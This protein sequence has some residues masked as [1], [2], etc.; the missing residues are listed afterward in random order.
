MAT[1]NRKDLEFI[2]QQIQVA[3]AHA[4]GADLTTLVPTVFAPVGLRTVDG[5][6]NNLLPGQSTFGAA[7]QPF[8]TLIDPQFSPPYNAPGLVFDAQ[9]RVIS[10][11]VADMSINNPAA[12]QAFVQAGLGSIR[13][14]DGALLDADGNVI[15]PNAVLTIP[16]VTP[17]VGLS[18]PYN[19]WFTFFGQFFDHGLDLVNKNPAEAVIIPLQPDDPLF[20][21]AP[22]APNFMVLSRTLHDANGNAVNQTTPF[23][24]QNQTYTSHASH[25]VFLREYVLDASGHPVATGKLLNHADG[26]LPTWADVKTQ[27]HNLLH[28]DL[29]NMDVLNLPLLVTDP[30]GKFVPGPNGFP[31]LVINAGPPPVTVS[32]TAG[33][34]VDASAGVRTGHPFLADIA[35]A[36]APVSDT[37]GI[38]TA[39][40]DTEINTGPQAPG[41]YDDELLDR[42]YIT[43]DG[44]GNENIALTSVHHV[45]HSEHNRQIEAIKTLVTGTGDPDFIASWHLADGSWNG[46]RLF[47]A[48]RFATEMQY[49]HLVF[50]EF[51]RRVQP[52]INEF[53]VPDGYNV[54][55]D[56]AIVAEFAHAVF[57][58]GHT[59]L[60]E[61]VDRFDPNFAADDKTLIEA[62]LNPVGFNNNGD[63]SPEEAAG[64]IVRGMTRQVGNE[65]DEF[66]T[67]AVRNN[68]LGLPLD[69]AALN[70]ARGR[71]TGLPSLNEARRE[72]FTQTSESKLAPY[73]SWVDLTQH[74][75]HEASAI[76]FIAAYGTHAALTAADV[77]TVEEKRAVAVALVMGGSATINAG[78]P[79]ERIFTADDTDRL[80]F[81]NSTGA[82]ANTPAG[83]TT[84]GVDDIDLWIGGLAERQTPFGGLL[85]STFNFVF[86]Q[87]LENL[88]NGD[89]FYYLSRTAGMHFGTELENNS[90]A[91]LVMLNTDAT[92]LPADIFSTPSWIFEVDQLKQYTGLGAGGHDDPTGGTAQVPLVIRDD[93]ATA[94]PDT[95]YLRYTGQDHVVLGGT[96][97]NDTLISS[98]GDDTFYGDEGNDRIEG[99]DG[100]DMIHGGAGDDIITDSGGDDVI[101]GEA[102]NDVIHGGNGL[103]LILGQ[104]GNDFIITGEDISTTFA[105]AGNDFIL[106]SK[107]NLPTLGNEGDDWIELGTQDGAGGDNFDPLGLGTIIGHDVFIT[108]G[109]FDEGEGEGGDDIMVMSDGEDRFTG[110]GGFDWGSYANDTEGVTGDLALNALIEPPVVGSNQGIKDKF[111]QVE[112]LSGSS[113]SD[114]LHGS[115]LDVVPV[116]TASALLGTLT[117]PSLYAGMQELLGE[118]VTSFGSG[119][120]ILGGGGSDILD[121]REDDD[122]LDGDRWLNVRISVRANADGTGPEIRS[123]NSMQDLVPDMLSGAIN[124]GQLQIVR[125]ILTGAPDFDTAMYWGKFSEYTV[126]TNDDGSITVAH[127][128]DGGVTVGADGIDTLRN[129]ERI[130][131]ADVAINFA[132]ELNA[133]PVGE[134]TI[135]DT[136]PAVN[137]LLTVSALG[138]T[139]LDNLGGIVNGRPISYFWQVEQA[140]GTGVFSDIVIPFG[141]QPTFVAG[142]TFTVTPDLDGLV[143]RVRG[144]YQDDH[145]VLEN[146]YSLPTTAVA[147]SVPVAPVTPPPAETYV[148][149]P[150][151]GVHLIRND[152]EFMLDQIKIAEANSGAYGTPSQDIPS[153]IMNTRLPFG[154]RTVDGTLNNLT[155][156][157]ETF[158]ASD[159]NFPLL[160][161]QVFR[162]EQDDPSFF[163]VSNN[164]YAAVVR[165]ANGNVV[166]D[167]NGVPLV[168]NVVDA[169]PRIISNLIVDQTGSN[170]AAV[171]ANGGADPIMSPGLDGVFGTPDDRPVFFI[172]NVTPDVGLSSPFNAWFTFFGQFFDHGLDLVDK[173]STAVFIP[174]QADDPLI[175]GADN[176]LNTPDDLPASQRFMVLSRATNTAVQAGTDGVLGTADDVHFH[177]NETTPFVDQNQTYTSHASHQA[178]LRAYKTVGGHTVSTGELLDGADGGIGNWAEVKAQA[179]TF[180]GIQLTDAD[181]FD[182]PLLAT[183]AYG[184]FIPGAHGFAQV[185]TNLGLIEGVAGGL[186]LRNLPGGALVGRSGHAF[187][188][189]IAH[190]AVPVF[191]A[192]GNLAPDAGTQIGNAVPVNAQG[193]NLAYDNELLD[194]HFITGD[195]RGNENIGLTTVHFIFH[196]EHN[197]LVHHIKEVAL[198]SNDVSFA[199]QWLLSDIT[200][201]DVNAINGLTGDAKTLAIE[202]LNWN[203]ERLFQAA[204]FG[205]EMQYQHLV[206]EE[207]ARRVQPNIDPFLTEG[208]GY[209][210][211]IDPAIVA[212]FAHVVYRFGHSMLNETVDRFDPNLNPVN[213]DSQQLGLIAAFLNP[214]AFSATG[215]TDAQSAGAIVR[216]LTRQT[217]NEIDEF[218]TEA[219]RSNL[220]GLPL[221]LPALNIARA[222]DAGVPSLNQA[223]TQFFDITGDAQ[224]KPYESWADLG[225]NLKHYE[226]LVNFVA[227]YGKHASLTGATTLAA[228]RAAAYAL[229]YGADGLDGIAGTADDTTGVPADRNA[230]MNGPAATT[231]VNDID[232]WIG[233]LAE[234]QMPFGGLLGS[235]FN[236]VF[237]NQ[238]EKLQDGDRFYYLER[239]AG[240]N[241][242]TE[243][244]QNSFQKLISANTDAQ[245][246]PGFV[247]SDMA[248]TLEVDPTKQLTGL[249]P[250]GSAN[251][252]GRA[253]PLGV[254]IRDDPSTAGADTHYL[255]YT[256]EDHV[257]LGGTIG[258]DTM[259]AGIGDDALHGDRGDDRLDGGDGNDIIFGEDGDD[260]ITNTGGDDNL[261]GG[262]GNDAIHGGNGVVLVL[263]GFGNDYIVTGEDASEVFG[264]TGNDFIS[265]T[266][267]TEFIFGNE[268]D[269][270]LEHGMVD[271]SSGDNFDARG[272]DAVVG[273]DVFFG[274]I[275]GDRMF[276]EGGDDIMIGNGG[277][278]D[279]YLGGS[280]F[281][282]A[283]FK[284]PTLG[285]VA[286]MNLRVFNPTAATEVVPNT[287]ARFSFV[288]GMSGSAFSDVLVGDDV[289]SVGILVAGFTGSVLRNFD[290][291][292]GLRGFVGSAG[293]GADGLAGTADDQ[294]DSGNIILGGEGSDILEGRGGNDLI[295]GDRWLDV[296]ISVR[297]N[298]DGTGPE[299]ARSDTMLALE[300]RIFSGEINPG[301]L[302]IVRQIM[303]GTDPSFDT[304]VYRG[305]RGEYTVVTGADGVTTVTHNLLDAAGAV[306]GV[307]IDGIDRLTHIE[308]LQFSNAVLLLVPPGSNNGPAGALSIND[309]TPAVGQ[310]LT[311]S[312]AGVTD[313]DNVSATNLTG[314]V[315]NVSYTWQSE[316]APGSGQFV[317]ISAVTP[318]GDVLFT[319]PTYRPTTTDAGL[320]L[321]VKAIYQD[322]HGVMETL[323][324]APTAAVLDGTPGGTLAVSDSTPTEA[325]AVTAVNQITDADGLAGVVFHYQWQ[326]STD[327]GGGP[328]FRNIAGAT[329]QN[330]TPTQD[331]VNRQLR[332]VVTYTDNGGNA[333][334]A[335]S[336]AT[337]VTG[338]V[339][340]PNSATQVLFGTAGQDNMNA[341]AG[342]DTLNGLDGNDNLTG[343]TGNDVVNGGNGNDTLHYTLGD[344]AD[345]MDGG[346]GQDTLEI[347]GTVGNNTLTAVFDGTVLTTVAGMAPTGIEVIT[348]DLLAGVDSLT[349]AGTVSAV[350]VDLGAGTASGF[351]SIAGIE[352]VT[353]GSGN[354]VLADAAGVANVL[355]GGTGNDTYVVHESADV[356]VEAGAAGTD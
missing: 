226:S 221:D 153:L 163:G 298:K 258:N 114:I 276:G 130:Q 25:Q 322:A 64:A 77:D 133:D 103:N 184:K 246:L 315:S 39:D 166:L 81:L 171:A 41:F 187:L 85:G 106:G 282:W 110:G 238:L 87:Q 230:F 169:D 314:A 126:T 321:R 65:I 149:N 338:D 326:E 50:E 224:L 285:A 309:A 170:P 243:L 104:D 7:D 255:H 181:I 72:F 216:G 174:L 101:H 268:G 274:D 355:I 198:A 292:A 299:I 19:S 209:D 112:G 22:G 20:S 331:Q 213:G 122:L 297:A 47:Q 164:N 109:G 123:V 12:V 318:A 302:T 118:G 108:G 159:Q 43:G 351:A 70:I 273:N 68:L 119:D 151:G 267:A 263:G 145:G 269:D 185:V 182:V 270:W 233:G 60:T 341:G 189:D 82:Y 335:T 218:V 289:D 328:T 272:L 62:F 165:D 191:D 329:T 271:G 56:P 310:L 146:V 24:D 176:I 172:P 99:G 207:F 236:F 23:V 78:T 148:A 58:V 323:Y 283:N 197:R 18:A 31:Q 202:S 48:A 2:L 245:H 257:V 340:A 128:I 13:T 175:R 256:G 281:D 348:A 38:L 346:A 73:T 232:L 45:F 248:Y 211:T 160:L 132:P 91:D 102:G 332:V 220:L 188:N 339:V 17:D 55:I 284:H 177:N 266:S 291:I 141:N 157:Q 279:R 61:T 113:H 144:V 21:T 124:P 44:R 247:F 319:G 277:S 304:A 242:R 115:K 300:D 59:M 253:D 240:L 140:P 190:N 293:N 86:E 231:G 67:S 192:N 11:L 49:Q 261:Q 288:E 97:G 244:E 93:P 264:G 69:L 260:I 143:L 28:I 36:A 35:H 303:P 327:L 96:S 129:I 30:Y 333:N 217:G 356:I 324:L 158:G 71:D 330:F 316:T 80:D 5:S 94:G 154:L 161:D 214:L 336:D 180:L 142:P 178:F 254:V 26:G 294:F 234:K 227:A 54:N 225:L 9:P 249:N 74:L 204:R 345:L 116:G 350:A 342:N 34:F 63:L 205:T 349:Y 237:E 147:G 354:D 312:A 343:G 6:F 127:S 193:Q 121:G 4:G 229:V 42:H 280:G 168:Q 105:G 134:L 66:V 352:N 286:D 222:R 195:G 206:F 16:N 29:D 320:A 27:A 337:I 290:L 325:S 15:G 52:N 287:G 307:G 259:I 37:G 155:P 313:A 3:E 32:A 194:K 90:F 212:E 344:G 306:V 120:I 84:T 311:V 79:E 156:G 353:G 308:R 40:T 51:A 250:D 275:I 173:S 278:V 208:Q 135:S 228:K 186:D 92:H 239:T 317:D 183:D 150:S 125:E 1:L 252:A 46:E 295:D 76:N 137:Q 131:F 100:N 196:A 219:L 139:D 201:A 334:T 136:T 179:A 75:K 162:N 215:G 167:A 138:L 98:I 251:P 241:F 200:Q 53:L 10:N 8:P 296:Y 88:Q 57:R 95:N 301:Q 111:F 199:N 305:A 83:V 14:S 33:T 210:A 89:R 107:L 262:D 223:R 235:T 152:L 117:N 265:G 203:G 347:R